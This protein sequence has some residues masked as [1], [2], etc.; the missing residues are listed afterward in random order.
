[1]TIV[2]PP[3]GVSSTTMLAA[4]RLDE[5]ARD[6]EAEPDAACRSSVA[7]AL[8]RSEDVLALGRRDARAVVD[9]PQVDAL[10]APRTPRRARG[11]RR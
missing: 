2:T 9:D 10:A 3:P 8:E 4:H 6:R 1:M 7:E 11:R 5:P